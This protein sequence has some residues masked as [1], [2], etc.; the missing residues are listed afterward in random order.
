MSQLQPLTRQPSDFVNLIKG[1]AKHTSDSW[2]VRMLRNKNREIKR[3]AL[4]CSSSSLS[5]ML[6]LF[7]FSQF[8]LLSPNIEC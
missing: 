3:E 4:L 7:A 5:L 1:S 2:S 8:H 6:P